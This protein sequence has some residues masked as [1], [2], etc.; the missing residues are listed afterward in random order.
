MSQNYKISI[1]HVELNKACSVVHAFWQVMYITDK[2][3]MA[4][5]VLDREIQLRR[6]EID[7]Y[8]NRKL[9]ETLSKT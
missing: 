4:V 7:E 9:Q 6:A 5:E 2:R 3:I 8:K 1:N